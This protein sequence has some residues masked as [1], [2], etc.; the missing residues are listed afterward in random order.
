MDEEK[1]DKFINNI[2]PFDMLVYKG[3]DM[4]SKTL[5]KIQKFTTGSGEASHV[6]IAMNQEYCYRIRTLEGKK[7]LYTWGSTMSGAFNGGVNDAE[8]LSMFFGVQFRNLKEV[9]KSLSGS[10][11]VG[12]CRLIDNPIERKEN[13]S[14]DD[15]AARMKLLKKK[16]SKLYKK[17]NKRSYNTDPVALT[18]ALFPVLGKLGQ[19][20]HKSNKGLFCSE[21][22][23]HVYIDLGII[24]D[25]TDGV[26]D[27]VI[28]IDPAVV[29]PVDL[30]DTS[31]RSEFKKAI[32]EAPIWYSKC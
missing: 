30:M 28:D 2:R 8:T 20:K 14:D 10:A 21:F 23:S 25:E 26:K 18:T 13:E 24:N 11:D 7:E 32:C 4:V 12:V 31:G 17:Y 27:D 19:I 9:I 1:I 5:R 3:N 29:L 15:Y 16:M 6:E 22:V